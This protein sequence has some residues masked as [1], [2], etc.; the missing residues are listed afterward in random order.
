MLLQQNEKRCFFQTIAHFS[1]N[2]SSEVKVKF[3]VEQLIAFNIEVI[4]SAEPMIVNL[5]P[6]KGILAT[7]FTGTNKGKEGQTMY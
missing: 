7:A 5:P 3:R 1:Q 4:G 6:G 2:L